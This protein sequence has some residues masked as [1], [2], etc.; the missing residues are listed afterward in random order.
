MTDR[1][2]AKRYDELQKWFWWLERRTT[3]EKTPK[4]HLRTFLKG[5]SEYFV[6][7]HSTD[8]FTG[9]FEL[10]VDDKVQIINKNQ[11]NYPSQGTIVEKDFN[12]SKVS[13]RFTELW[14]YDKDL[15]KIG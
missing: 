2:K 5:I 7:Y 15:V 6:P 8:E 12:M 13:F 14:Y 9:R 10:R 3:D 4:V 1:E 11:I